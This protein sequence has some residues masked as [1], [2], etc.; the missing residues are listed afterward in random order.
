MRSKGNEYENKAYEFLLSKGLKLVERNYYCRSGEI[1][2]IMRDKGTIVFVEVRF[3]SSAV[4]GSA[5]ESISK[6]KQ[7]KLINTAHMFLQ[8][9]QLY[10]LKCRF[11]TISFDQT[12]DGIRV[13]WITSAFDE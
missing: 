11:D 10:T 6:R 1:D 3:R 4:Y 7:R 9:R 13:N 2:L 5:T 12:K 8:S